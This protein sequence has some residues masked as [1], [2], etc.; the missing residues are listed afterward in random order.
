VK[1][2]YVMLSVETGKQRLFANYAVDISH[3]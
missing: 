1:G 2:I 3:D